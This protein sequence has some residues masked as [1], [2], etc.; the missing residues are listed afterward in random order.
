MKK[1][2]L[3]AFCISISTVIF[4]QGTEWGVKT[5][6]NLAG[7]ATYIHYLSDKKVRPGIYAGLFVEHKF[8]KFFGIQSELLYSMMGGRGIYQEPIEWD[9]T[10]GLFPQYNP[11]PEITITNKADYIVLPILAKL[12]VTKNLSLDF[13]PQFG[14]MI[15]AKL[16]S[17]VELFNGSYYDSI[18]NNNVDVL[19]GIGL[20]Y[21]LN[22]KFNISGRCNFGL[23]DVVDN[24]RVKNNVIQVGVGYKLR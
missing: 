19:F 24:S 22:S 2:I 10:A 4:A 6:L 18:Y 21:K 9:P 14:Y 7:R 5:G 17:Q 13:G 3:L 15:S 20:S 8:N 23:V 12:Y 11:N 1:I 16:K